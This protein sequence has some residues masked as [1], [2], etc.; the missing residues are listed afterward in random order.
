MTSIFWTMTMQLRYRN[1]MYKKLLYYVIIENFILIPLHFYSKNFR[2][3]TE[4]SKTVIWHRHKKWPL[5]PNA[6]G[7]T[8]HFTD[9]IIEKKNKEVYKEICAVS[10]RIYYS[11]LYYTSSIMIMTFMNGQ[12]KISNTKT[13][14]KLRNERRNATK[15]GNS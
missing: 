10:I 8:N 13:K 5:T 11:N 1:Y 14:T 3:S 12:K 4:N 15:W 2:L 7:G 6:F 9:N